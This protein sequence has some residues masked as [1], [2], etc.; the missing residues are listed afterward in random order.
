MRRILLTIT[1]FIFT[2]ALKSGA[3][4]LQ[5]W[6]LRDCM[7]Y[8]IENSPETKIQELTNDNRRL[9]HRDAY[10]EFV[11]SVNGNINAYTSFGRSIDP[12]TNT[13]SNVNSF[14]NSY[15]IYSNYTIFNGFTVVDKYKVTRI[16]R[17]SGIEE[18]RQVEDNL[19]LTI[20]QS[21]YNVLYR[22]GMVQLCREQLMES[23]TTLKNTRVL[24]ELGLKSYADVLQV[25]AQVAANDYNLVREQNMMES[26]LIS[27]KEKMFFP[28]DRELVIDTTFS[29]IADPFAG[30]VTAGDIY[31]SALEFLPAVKIS[32]FDVKTA[33]IKL[34]NAKWSLLPNNGRPDGA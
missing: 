4:E 27:L 1:F 18:A 11:P 5:V 8:A 22:K 2:N 21:Y 34:H 23:Q 7:I 30:S 28:S 32:A 24:E 16:A 20:M 3:Q 19:C 12:E 10:L 31:L 17:L 29:Q 14:S 25:E 26:E 33:G 13:Y 9:D 15:A 6:T